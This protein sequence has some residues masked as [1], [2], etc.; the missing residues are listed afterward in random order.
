MRKAAVFKKQTIYL[1][2]CGGSDQSA[3]GV[4][5]AKINSHIDLDKLS[6]NPL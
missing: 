2:A 6:I 1:P 4:C 5:F 3:A